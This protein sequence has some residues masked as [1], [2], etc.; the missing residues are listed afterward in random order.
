MKKR[1]NTAVCILLIA[2]MLLTATGC[3]RTGAQTTP[4]P[5]EAPVQASTA[6]ETETSA[7][8]TAI[9]VES[10]P[11]PEKNGD[12]VILYTSDIHCGIDQGFGLAGLE[13]VRDYL[14]SQG[15]DV[16]LVDDGDHLQ[17]EPIGTM[18]KGDALVDLMNDMGYSIA[19]PGN[20][21]F[22]YGMDNFLSLAKKAKYT[23]ISCKFNHEGELLFQPYVIRELAGNKVILGVAVGYVDHLAPLALALYVLL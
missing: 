19:I 18:T 13:A 11:E 21:E 12:I 2:V 3:S 20:H 16:I 10:T 6:A 15:N 1:R 4:P 7:A 22:D 14:I 5:T 23:Y 8:E 9:P 17:G